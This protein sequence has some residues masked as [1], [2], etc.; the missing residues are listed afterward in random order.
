MLRT[1]LLASV[2][3]CA[4]AAHAQTDPA[5]D[6]TGDIVVTGTRS[7]GRAALASSAPIDV[8]SGDAIADSGFSDLGR[9]LNFL[10]P[11]VN[12]AR[13]ATTANAANT[14]PV[15]LRGPSPDQTLVMINAKRSHAN[16][17][18]NV[19]HSIGRGTAGRHPHTQ[20]ETP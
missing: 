14:K 2:A 18:L 8:I 4:T 5:T 15:T 3:L 16:A 12:F 6:K 10:Q 1:F 13:A 7:V 11:S 17:V 9:A 20:P 19:N